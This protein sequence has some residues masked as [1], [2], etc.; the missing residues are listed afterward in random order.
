MIIYINKHPLLS[1]AMFCILCATAVTMT[2]IIKGKP[3]KVSIFKIIPQE[4]EKSKIKKE[5]RS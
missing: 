5:E 3:T 1:F 2:E 4:Q